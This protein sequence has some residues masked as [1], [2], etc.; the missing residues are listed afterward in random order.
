MR[1]TTLRHTLANPLPTYSIVIP[2]HNE[3]SYLT[4]A[5]TELHE[6]LGE[7]AAN[8]ELIVVENGSNDGTAAIAKATLEQLGGSWSTSLLRLPVGDYGA[9]L[10]HGFRHATG[11]WIVSF[12]IDYFDVPF[13]QALSTAD[14]DVVLA[15]KRH[16][17][18]ADERSPYRRLATVVFNRLLKAIVGSELS[19]T[20]GIKALRRPWVTELV[21]EVIHDQDLFDTELVLRAERAGATITEVPIAVVERREARSSLLKRVPRTVRG[22]VQLRGAL[23]TARRNTTSR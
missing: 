15:S 9:A 3:A 20:H 19:D 7:L 1:C 6:E 17:A 2:V 22:L 23:A 21:D 11:D 14:A 10:R 12:D 18:S 8:C 4:V 5:L 16:D 13:L